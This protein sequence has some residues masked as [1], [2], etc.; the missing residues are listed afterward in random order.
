MR[1]NSARVSAASALS[2]T[3]R[4]RRTPL[5]VDVPAPGAACEIGAP[6]RGRR[7]VKLAPCPGPALAA[8]AAP[9]CSS[10]IRRTS[11][12]PTPSPPSV[13]ASV[14]FPCT[15]GWNSSAT[16]DG[17]SPAPVSRTTISS[18]GDPPVRP[19]LAPDA[20]LEAPQRL[21]VG[22]ARLCDLGSLTIVGVHELHVR[23]RE[24][25]VGGPPEDLGHR[26][27]DALPSA[28][29]QGSDREHV[30]GEIEE[31]GQL[32]VR[33][34]PRRGRTSVPLLDEVLNGIRDGDVEPCVEARE[35]G[36]A[37]LALAVG[38]PRPCPLLLR[39]SEERAEDDLAEQSQLAEELPEAEGSVEPLHD[40]PE[41]R[42]TQPGRAGQGPGLQPSWW[43]RAATARSCATTAP[44][45]VAR[46]AVQTTR[47]PA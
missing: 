40:V 27:V 31:P 14:R 19:V 20:V 34:R 32:G 24:Q 42:R 28:V 13:R 4:T 43:P 45:S 17:S 9:P 23:R 10:A 16:S 30:H 47:G 44:S 5:V 11:A 15:K 36:D 29:T 1:R 25:L 35:L 8:A 33:P 37:L 39:C 46:M 7:T 26:R 6:A 12:S 3:T 22:E 38:R 41:R 2:S 18:E 21:P